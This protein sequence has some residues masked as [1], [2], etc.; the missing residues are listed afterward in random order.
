MIQAGGSPNPGLEPLSQ[1]TFLDAAQGAKVVVHMRQLN[2]VTHLLY[3]D[4]RV[5]TLAPASL[6]PRPAQGIAGDYWSDELRVA[7]R[8]SAYGQLGTRHRSGKWIHLLLRIPDRFD[9]NEG[10]WSIAF[11]RNAAAEVTDLK[12]SGGRHSQ[13]TLQTVS[14]PGSRTPLMH[15][16]VTGNTALR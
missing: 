15:L 8:S 13:C 12:V 14:L 9:T 11:T 16:A 1:R 6:Q 7:Y 5:P 2:S 4:L 10:G 3:R